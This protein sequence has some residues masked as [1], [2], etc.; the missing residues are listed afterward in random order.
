MALCGCE[1]GG[2]KAWRQA[3]QCLTH[4]RRKDLNAFVRQFDL[5][6]SEGSGAELA[7]VCQ[8]SQ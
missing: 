7:F 3:Q 6:L 2:G 4:T 1:L 8:L 5:A